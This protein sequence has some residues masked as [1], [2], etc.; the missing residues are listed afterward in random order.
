MRIGY[1]ILF[2]FFIHVVCFS[3]TTPVDRNLY[4]EDIKIEGNHKTNPSVILHHLTFKIGDPLDAET[5]LNNILILQQT[6]FFKD[7]DI[8]TK[9]G[10]RKG[11]VIVVVEVV[12]YKWPSYRFEGGHSDLNGWYFSPIGFRMNNLFGHGNYL[13]YN[14]KFGNRISGNYLDYK[15]PDLAQSRMYLGV[16]LFDET[17]DFVHYIGEKDTTD[18]VGSSGIRLKMGANKGFF[19]HTFLGY[20]LV[21]YRPQMVTELLPILEEDYDNK[22]VATVSTGL[23]TDTRDNPEFPTAGLWGAVTGELALPWL[24]SNTLFPKLIFDFR[25]YNKISDHAV[26]AFHIKG[27]VTGDKAPYYER[28]Y[29]GGSYSLRGYSFSRL[30]PPGWGT[31]LFLLQN[32]FRFPLGQPDPHSPGY[33]HTLVMFYDLGGIWRSREIPQILDIHHSIG[34]GYRIKLPIINILRFDIAYPISYS[35]DQD[36]HFHLSLGQTF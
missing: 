32:E 14:M 7:V 8:Y 13:S 28:F 18:A 21:Y 10:S 27:G 2:L 29:L 16:Q 26:Y 11:L 25:N 30:S 33:K 12:E 6:E 1:K 31:K 34:L 19:Q 20:R 22:W 24:G 5:I 4:I 9:P 15:K 35:N 36:I 23:T 3:Q 17:Q